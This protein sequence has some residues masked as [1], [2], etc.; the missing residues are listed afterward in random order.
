M[1]KNNLLYTSLSVF[2]FLLSFNLQA[3]KSEAKIDQDI[4]KAQTI[5]G[6]YSVAGGVEVG[7]NM[8]TE[9]KVL[10]TK[11]NNKG[12]IIY[13]SGRF[14][15]TVEGDK[16]SE[17]VYDGKKAYLI[18]YPD[19]ELDPKGKRKIIVL[20]ETDR[21]QVGI[22]LNL[23]ENPKKYF[24]E[25]KI[26]KLE[27]KNDILKLKLE[28]KNKKIKKPITLTFALKGGYLKSLNYL[29]DVDSVI[30]VD[31][32]SPVFPKSISKN[33]FKYNALKNDEVIRQ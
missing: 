2:T 9:K 29:D 27:N 23:M 31:L 17:M 24:S 28:D 13:Q 22:L 16:K 33:V 6:K 15:L 26:T 30:S 3:K 11:T 32:E 19:I 25:F 18:S 20:K 5:M 7:L 12:K 8:T 21:S 14:N 10:G 1:G 4:N